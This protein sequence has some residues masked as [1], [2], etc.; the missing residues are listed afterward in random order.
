A[1]RDARRGEASGSSVW[2]A[3]DSLLEGDGFELPVPGH[4]ELCRR[5]IPRSFPGEE[6]GRKPPSEC[7]PW[8]SFRYPCCCC[9]TKRAANHRPP[10]QPRRP[11]SSCSDSGRVAYPIGRQ[12]RVHPANSGGVSAAA[13]PLG[14][15]R[16][17]RFCAAVSIRPASSNLRGEAFFEGEK[18]P[19]T[20][21]K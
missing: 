16:Q 8:I 20:K 3:P 12:A 7:L 15:P 18:S 14:W 5:A 11:T 21:A 4:G 6:T 17:R 1:S 10:Q 9:C 19:Q 2:F 13:A